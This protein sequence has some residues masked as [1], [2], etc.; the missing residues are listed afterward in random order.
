MWTGSEAHEL[1]TRAKD[2]GLEGDANGAGLSCQ[3]GG[4][5]RSRRGTRR[6]AEEVRGDGG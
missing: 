2:E 5:G 4:R 1:E 3:R 6:V